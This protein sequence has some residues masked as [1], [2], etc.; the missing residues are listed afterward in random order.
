MG[1]L[2]VTR[3]RI[4]REQFDVMR[5]DH[6]LVSLKQKLIQSEKLSMIYEV[7]TRSMNFNEYHY[8]HAQR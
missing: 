3:N 4:K 5:S 8:Q 1:L 2:V 6:S 7:Y